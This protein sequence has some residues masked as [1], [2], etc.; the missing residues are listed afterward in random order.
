MIQF[1]CAASVTVIVYTDEWNVKRCSYLFEKYLRICCVS[2][3]EFYTEVS[4]W[5]KKIVA[6]ASATESLAT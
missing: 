2:N 4:K 5:K 3:S 6:A 1:P